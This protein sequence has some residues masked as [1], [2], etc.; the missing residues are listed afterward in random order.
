MNYL[1]LLFCVVSIFTLVS[2]EVGE[3]N[4]LCGGRGYK[5]TYG[6]CRCHSDY[7]GE[8]CEYSKQQS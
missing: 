2:S 8:N 4:L 1:F 3:K 5:D 7:H 6:I